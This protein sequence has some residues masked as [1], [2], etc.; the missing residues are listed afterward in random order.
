MGQT[1]KTRMWV[2]CSCYLL[3]GSVCQSDLKE[4]RMHPSH[5]K[6]QRTA[7]SGSL[8]N[9]DGKKHHL[10]LKFETAGHWPSLMSVINQYIYDKSINGIFMMK[11]RQWKQDSTEIN[12]PA[13]M[14][15]RKKCS[16]TL[17]NQCS[18]FLICAFHLLEVGFLVLRL[19]EGA[20]ENA[21]H[22]WMTHGTELKINFCLTKQ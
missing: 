11:V 22:T 17:Q 13:H 1:R 6:T 16:R 9:K 21:E 4:R 10:E 5:S 14:H 7:Y 20:A 18:L 19:G 2:W 8:L 3:P 12:K 15:Q